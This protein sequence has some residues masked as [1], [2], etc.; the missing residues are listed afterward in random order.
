MIGSTEL[1]AT[2]AVAAIAT[3]VT[4][5]ITPAVG[6]LAGLLGMHDRP[7]GRKIHARLVPY[8]GGIAIIAGWVVAFLTPGAFAQSLTLVGCMV[9][10][11]AVG[12]VDDRYDISERL[13]L[14]IQIAIAVLAYAGGI[15]MT[16]LDI[17]LPDLLLTVVWLVGMTNAFNFMDN[18]DGLAAGVGGIGA[19]TL[20]IIGALHGQRLVSVLGL[21][22]A[23][24]CA[25]FLR[26]NFHPARIFMGDTGSLPLGFGL[27]ALAIKVEFPGL[28]PLVA[29]S[30]PVVVLGLF[31]IDTT[32]MT[33]GRINR[34]EP[35]IGARLDHISHRLLTKELPVRTVAARMYAVAAALGIAGTLLTQLPSPLPVVVLAG[36]VLASIWSA[37]LALSWPIM[38]GLETAPLQTE[39][40]A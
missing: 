33:L 17:A 24:A 25:G 21:S 32:V 29:F 20:G 23:G 14:G 28:H 4:Y 19:A 2:F 39:A 3:G 27:A 35:V 6:R 38:R 7:S 37:G 9:A 18:M 40:R 10:L 15:R 22:L 31:I 8:L 5:G 34:G 12:F 16:P 30:V 1:I 13:R 26:H 11:L 36:V